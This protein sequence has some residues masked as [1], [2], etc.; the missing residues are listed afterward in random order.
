LLTLRQNRCVSLKIPGE[1]GATTNNRAKTMLEPHHGI[2]AL[3]TLAF[4][5]GSPDVAPHLPRPAEVALTNLNKQMAD[6]GGK[7]YD[8][9]MKVWEQTAQ[10]TGALTEKAQNK[11]GQT[12]ATT[13]T[14]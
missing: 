4:V 8:A 11:L 9:S 7:V 2:I 6:A 1:S 10:F 13:P 5:L 12:T 14:S 3:F